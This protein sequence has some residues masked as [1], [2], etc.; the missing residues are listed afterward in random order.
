MLTL[1]QIRKRC[2]VLPSGCWEWQGC[3]QG[4]AYGRIRHKGRTDYAHRAAYVAANG[5]IP[6]DKELCHRC[7]YRRCCNPAHLFTG[8]R[9]DNMADAVRKGR[10]AKGNALPHAKLTPELIQQA[11]AR[12]RNGESCISIATSL[13]VHPKTLSKALRG[14]TWRHQHVVPQ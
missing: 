12:R 6:D 14:K 1:D 13:E 5:P 7:D 3:V 10:Q 2:I 8:T 11:A 4:N 9:A